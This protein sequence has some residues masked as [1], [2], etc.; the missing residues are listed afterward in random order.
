MTPV[1]SDVRATEIENAEHPLI[2]LAT[3]ATDALDSA[4]QARDPTKEP[5]AVYSGGRPFFVD[6][7]MLAALPAVL[8]LV[9]VFV[10]PVLYL[11]TNSLHPPAGLAQVGDEFTLS[12]YISFL[13]DPF[14]LGLMGRT[15]WLSAIVV[16][17]CILLG[18]PVAYVLARTRSRW[19][20]LLIFVVVSPLLI[21]V[22]I[23][24]LGWLPI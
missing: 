8:T 19:R 15:F 24:N 21:S 9:A 22:V 7:W 1:R 20:S 14:Y 10:V 3:S 5:A 11:A 17:A 23:R 16:F 12:N 18:Y 4:N 6:P 2:G 13:T